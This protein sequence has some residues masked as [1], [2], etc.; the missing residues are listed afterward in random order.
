MKIQKIRS[1]FTLLLATL[2]VSCSSVAGLFAT[3]TPTPTPT[4]TPTLT[5]TPFPLAGQSLL[6]VT[7]CTMGGLPQKMDIYFPET[8]GPWPVVYYVHGGSWMNGDKAEAEG[9]AKWLNPLGYLVASVN[10]RMYPSV[11]FPALIEDPKCG[12][13]FLRAHAAEYNIDPERIAAWGAS[14]GGHL[15]ALL[16]TTEASAGFDTGEYLEQSSRVQAVVDISGPSDLALTFKNSGLL[17]VIML[18]FAIKP[19]ARA[20]GSPVTYAT[21]DDPPFL[22]IHGDQDEVVPVEQGQ[23]MYDALTKVGAP[24]KL[25]IV[26][27]GRHNLADPTVTTTPSLSEVGQIQLDF[28]AETLL[29]G[30]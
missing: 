7:Y 20:F 25:V 6:D 2:L 9:L 26:K 24:A 27:N 29:K 21:A 1:F 16:G 3:P 19:E 4:L 23:V 15:V 30:K 28:L 17:T 14:A 5:P 10:Y 8:G 12:V 13:R 22:I 11:K 18:G